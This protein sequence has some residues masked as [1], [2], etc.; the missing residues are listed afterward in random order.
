[1]KTFRTWSDFSSELFGELQYYYQL[2][3]ENKEQLLEDEEPEDDGDILCHLIDCANETELLAHTFKRELDSF[4]ID[5]GA[6][7]KYSRE[8]YDD[9]E[10]WATDQYGHKLRKRSFFCFRNKDKDIYARHPDWQVI[11]KWANKQKNKLEDMG[12]WRTT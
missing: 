8:E 7:P 6:Y 11:I 10:I 4:Q 3:D 5:I 9:T 1:M 2:S 12:E